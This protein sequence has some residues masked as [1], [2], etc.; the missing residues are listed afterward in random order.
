[1]F[2]SKQPLGGPNMS[3]QSAATDGLSIEPQLCV[4]DVIQDESG[5][6]K[7]LALQLLGQ[8]TY[9]YAIKAQD[10][11]TRMQVVIKIIKYKKAHKLEQTG[12]NEVQNLL[13]VSLSVVLL[14]SIKLCLRL[15]LFMHGWAR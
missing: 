3:A 2:E 14:S 7:Y 13:K 1:M 10:L 6:R 15:K 4:N 8:G 12:R 11:I 9:G 5:S